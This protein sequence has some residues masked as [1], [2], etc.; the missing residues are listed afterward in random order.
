M[1]RSKKVHWNNWRV[2]IA[3]LEVQCE[4][5][6]VLQDLDPRKIRDELK[7]R[8]TLI[9][10]SAGTEKTTKDGAKQVQEFVNSN[11]RVFCDAV[12]ISARYNLFRE[13]YNVFLEKVRVIGSSRLSNLERTRT[14]EA[15]VGQRMKVELDAM[16]SLCKEF[17]VFLQAVHSAWCRANHDGAESALQQNQLMAEI[18]CNFHDEFIQA[19]ENLEKFEYDVRKDVIDKTSIVVGTSGALMK[20]QLKSLYQ[21]GNKRF[22]A[23]LTDESSMPEV[24]EEISKMMH[25][26]KEEIV[27]KDA[28]KVF[29]GDLTQEGPNISGNQKVWENSAFTR[30]NTFCTGVYPTVFSVFESSSANDL[31]A[32]VIFANAHRASHRV[33]PSTAEI[34]N[35]IVQQEILNYSPWVREADGEPASKRRRT[36]DEVQRKN[37]ISP[38]R[39]LLTGNENRRDIPK[40]FF[41][42]AF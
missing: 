10:G 26:C 42:A 1:D 35:A 9:E 19:R 25:L 13:L 5:N 17:N 33:G 32:N 20:P 30:Y 27:D 15:L 11:L 36:G 38:L 40:V 4:Q 34:I 3:D 23:L 29:I 6:P 16:K 18:L 37:T 39:P 14:L 2:P 12:T 8:L 22:G 7:S 28:K 31:P 21:L 41:D 24:G